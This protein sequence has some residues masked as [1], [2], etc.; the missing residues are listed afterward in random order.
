MGDTR[1]LAKVVVAG[2]G[3]GGLTAAIALRRAGFEVSVFER[4]AEL[5]EVGAGLLLASNA[6]KA[7]KKLGLAEAVSSLGTPASAAEIRSWRGKVLASIPA[8]ELEKKIGTSS[9][10]V[11]R[12]DLQAL[13]AREVGDGTLRVSAEVVGFEQDK[14]GVR[15]HF[16][17]GSQES[18][19]I[20]IGADGLRSRVRAGLF[21]PEEPRYAGYTA[22]RAVVKPEEEL[23]SWGAGFESWGIGARFGCAHIGDG[24][25]YWFATANAPEGEKDGPSGGLDGAKAK[26]LRLFSRWHR[27]VADLV[28]AAEEGAILRTDIYDREPLGERWGEGKVTLLGDAAHPMTPNLGQGACQAIEDAVVLARCL[29]EGGATAESLRRYERLRSA[30]VAMLVRRSRRIGSVGQVKN[31]AVCWLRERALA[32]IPPKAQLRQLEEVVGYEA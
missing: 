30:R 28:E 21:G 2:G 16:A 19:D 25:V 29:G 27:P 24:R 11:H 9:A 22:W 32:M 23:L 3:I 31:P 10:A 18:A 6:Q 14:G 20:L 12:A 17:D 26:L 4:A 8:A 13:L 15:V 5:G 7:L 1:Y